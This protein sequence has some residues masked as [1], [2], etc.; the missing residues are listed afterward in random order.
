MAIKN[1]MRVMYEWVGVLRRQE[2]SLFY[3]KKNSVLMKDT[4]K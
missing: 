1:S 2:K 4:L 3:T